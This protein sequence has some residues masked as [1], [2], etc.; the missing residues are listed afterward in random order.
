MPF[1]LM[2]SRFA[3]GGHHKGPLLNSLDQQC[4]AWLSLSVRVDELGDYG[5]G[6]GLDVRACVRSA[7]ESVTPHIYVQSLEPQTPHVRGTCH[8]T[9]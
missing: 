8:C 7:L 9:L 2:P 3:L 4:C 6:V 5:E 1:L